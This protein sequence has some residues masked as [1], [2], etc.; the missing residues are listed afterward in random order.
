MALTPAAPAA[1]TRPNVL[2]LIIDDLNTWLLED[3]TRYAGKVVAPNI[4]RLASEGVLFHNAYTASPVCVPSRTA[5][6]S[7]VAPW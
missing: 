7:G 3:P 2:F 4:Q 1:T 5:F 6:L